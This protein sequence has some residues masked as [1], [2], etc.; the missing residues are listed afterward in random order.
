MEIFR[1]GEDRYQVKHDGIQETLSL[2]EVM[3]LLSRPM[4]NIDWN[5]KHYTANEDFWRSEN[6]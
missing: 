1:V 6:D 5:K 3:L 2:N 4:S